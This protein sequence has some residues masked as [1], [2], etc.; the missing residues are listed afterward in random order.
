MSVA[1]RVSRETHE[2]LRQLAAARKQPI[3]QVVAAAVERL[4]EEAFWTEAADA[5][6]RLRSDPAAWEA[7]EAEFREWEVAGLSSLTDEPTEAAAP[8]EGAA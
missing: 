6:E 1:I 3:G 2:Q 8:A 7:Y 4:D 5:L